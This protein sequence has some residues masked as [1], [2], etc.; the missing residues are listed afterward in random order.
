[1][2]KWMICITNGL[3]PG[4]SSHSGPRKS[5]ELV[6][7]QSRG[8]AEHRRHREGGIWIAVSALPIG[9]VILPLCALVVPFVKRSLTSVR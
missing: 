1:M 5:K 6:I 7:P 8:N 9:I 4:Y 3:R 2:P